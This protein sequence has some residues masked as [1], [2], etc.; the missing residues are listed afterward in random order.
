MESPAKRAECT[1]C[2]S[3]PRTVRLS[4]G[5]AYCEQCTVRIFSEERFKCPMRC[6]VTSLAVSRS[7]CA[8][9]EPTAEPGATVYTPL[10]FLHRNAS[11]EESDDEHPA[12]AIARGH[13]IVPDGVTVLA[14]D[15]F[16][17]CYSLTS[18]ALPTSLV[19]IG[20]NAFCNCYCLTSITLPDG[21]A[22][23]GADAFSGCFSLASITLPESVREIG[24]N[25]FLDCSALTSIT[26]RGVTRI[27]DGAFSGCSAL[28]TV[29]L[30]PSLPR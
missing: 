24:A 21:L 16:C 19:T 14:S 2:F 22:V 5:H 15:A 8:S 26:L 6:E 18:I 23:I 9:Y 10:Q 12:Y 7:P 30:P 1:I 25:A 3:R 28:T 27:G 13:A 29:V 20:R 17:E 11:R 4:C